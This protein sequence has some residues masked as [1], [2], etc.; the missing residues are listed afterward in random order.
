MD[1]LDTNGL[2][3]LQKQDA[4]KLSCL[5]AECFVQDPLY[6]E[7]IPDEAKRRKMLPELFD[8]EMDDLFENCEIYADS[9][10][11]NGIVIVSDESEPYNAFTYYLKSLFYTLKTGACLVKDDPSLATLSNFVRGRDYLSEAWTDDIS[12]DERLHIIY[13]AVRPAMQGHGIAAKLMRAVLAKADE[14]HLLISLETHN[15]HN[16]EIYKHF[17]FS[18]FEVL[19]KHFALKQYCMVR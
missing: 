9:P 10:A 3:R 8:C 15:A 14:R 6:C 19:Q 7:L 1:F 5:L 11:I 4:E 16:V 2:Y 12:S 13:L 17:G 18:V